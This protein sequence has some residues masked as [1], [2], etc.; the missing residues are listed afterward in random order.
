MDGAGS[1]GCIDL[2]GGADTFFDFFTS[3]GQDVTLKVDYTNYDGTNHPLLD[4][5]P[6]TE[7]NF[8]FE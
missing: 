7:N 3:L 6:D 2:V 4:N 8:L 5:I 1:R